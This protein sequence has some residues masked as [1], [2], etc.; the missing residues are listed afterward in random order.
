MGTMAQG[1]MMTGDR[2]N[3]DKSVVFFNFCEILRNSTDSQTPAKKA[4]QNVDKSGLRKIKRFYE[5]LMKMEL[6][7][8]WDRGV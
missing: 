6:K 4:W 7:G 1:S 3:P 8:L 5:L 2:Q